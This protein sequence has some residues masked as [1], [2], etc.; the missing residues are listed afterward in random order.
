[1]LPFSE[2]PFRAAGR[3]RMHRMINAAGRLAE[4]PARVTVASR[5][6]LVLDLDGTLLKTDLLLECF[7]AAIK[8]NPLVLFFVLPWLFHGRAA[9]K[10]RLA[11]F[12]WPD[13]DTLPLDDELLAFAASEAAAGRSI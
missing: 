8:R 1:M 10:R 4:R 13:V 9:L 6:P 11:R 12:A 2:P 3:N 5:P 7:V